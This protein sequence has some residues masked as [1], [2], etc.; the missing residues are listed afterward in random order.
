MDIGFKLY[1][2]TLNKDIIQQIINIIKSL[3]GKWFT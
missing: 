1:Q 2:R 3:T